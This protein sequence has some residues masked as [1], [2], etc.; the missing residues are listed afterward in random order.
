MTRTPAECGQADT[1]GHAERRRLLTRRSGAA[2][3]PATTTRTPAEVARSASPVPALGGRGP[4]QGSGAPRVCPD[5]PG[6]TT[7]VGQRKHGPL[8]TVTGLT[9]RRVRRSVDLG[10]RVSIPRAPGVRS[11]PR[12]SPQAG[13]RPPPNPQDPH[14]RVRRS[15]YSSW[16]SRSEGRLRSCA[17]RARKTSA[18]QTGARPLFGR[19]RTS[20]PRAPAPSPWRRGGL[21]ARHGCRASRES[22]RRRA[23]MGRRARRRALGDEFAPVDPAHSSSPSARLALQRGTRKAPCDRGCAGGRYRT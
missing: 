11:A 10:P 19:S 1:R 9:G 21:R 18:L 6:V 17:T 22:G 15:R 14:I 12:R 8:R 5:V 23:L 3:V 20:R 7:L 13:R 16:A 4:P 2:I